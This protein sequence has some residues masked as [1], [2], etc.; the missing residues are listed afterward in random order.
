[1]E[2]WTH[3]QSGDANSTTNIESN[4]VEDTAVDSSEPSTTDAASVDSSE[5]ITTGTADVFANDDATM[6][7]SS[8]EYLTT[9]PCSRSLMLMHQ[10]RG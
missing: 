2:I 7:Q 9:Q 3:Y 1:M 5:P 6:E 10:W 4:E 8:S